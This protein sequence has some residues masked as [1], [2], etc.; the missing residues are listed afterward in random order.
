MR[1]KRDISH[2]NRLY[3]SLHCFV[4][5]ILLLSVEEERAL[6]RDKS[7]EAR[8][9]LILSHLPLVKSIAFSFNGPGVDVKDLFSEGV[10][11]LTKAVDRYAPDKGRLATFARHFIWGEILCYLNKQRT[12]L[13]LPDPLKRSV[14]QFQRACQHLGEGATDAEIAAAMACPP[15]TV[16]YF[17]ECSEHIFESLD[18]PLADSDEKLMLSETVGELDPGFA[19]VETQVLVEQ[20]LSQL[21]ETEREVIRLRYGVDD[22]IEMSLRTVGKHLG[23]SHEWAAKVEKA[24]LAKMRKRAKIKKVDT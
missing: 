23:K 13:H 2:P 5:G 6:A 19:A 15:E 4:S 12:L 20:F 21:S 17:R 14:N 16:G 11:G 24:A 10:I 9:R 1:T 22:R 8:D 3:T 18:A 7:P